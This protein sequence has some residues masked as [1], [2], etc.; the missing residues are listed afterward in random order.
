MTI[1]S[2]TVTYFFWA[3]AVNIILIVFLVITVLYFLNKTK[4]LIR[5]SKRMNKDLKKK[6]LLILQLQNQVKS[7][8]SLVHSIG[9]LLLFRPPK[10][11]YYFSE[12]FEMLIGYPADK[13][14]E[15]PQLYRQIIITEDLS[16]IDELI[17]ALKKGES[18]QVEFRINHPEEK[19]KWILCFA[20]SI[21]DS[22]GTILQINA[23]ILDISKRKTLEEELKKLAY[24]D[25]LTDL[26][27]RKALD[28]HLHKA[29]ARSKRHQHTL[30]IMFIDLDDFKIVND[31]LG[32]HAG[33]VLLM[34]VA[35]RF[36]KSIREEDYIARIGG[37][38]FIIVFE[39]TNKIE[40]K[41]ITE[42]IIHSVSKPY[43]INQMEA[44]ITLSIGISL[45]PDDSDNKDKLIAYADKAM[46]MAKDKGKN[47]YHFYASDSTEAE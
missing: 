11:E 42:R 13:I 9:G 31:T 24:T 6:N 46:Y 14:I 29:I 30:A 10:K 40:M 22:N 8:Q 2:M 17:N 37:D 19:E 38:E 5:E 44:S 21:I 33:D 16:I 28:R 26:S 41:K 3:K 7:H 32:H 15:N 20:K 34:E 47:Q 36:H 39:E 4:V 1:I 25:H 18:K 23:Q 45:Y 35:D 27:N 12:N 43:V